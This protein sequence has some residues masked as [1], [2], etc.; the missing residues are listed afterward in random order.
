MTGLIALTLVGVIFALLSMR[1]ALVTM[2]LAID[3]HRATVAVWR[4]EL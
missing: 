2:T 4:Y 3:R 1:E